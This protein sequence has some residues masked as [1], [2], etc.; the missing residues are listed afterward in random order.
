MKG[1]LRDSKCL[2]R[3]CNARKLT[4]A[5]KHAE[6]LQSLDD[7]I[8]HTGIPVEKVPKG[9]VQKLRGKGDTASFRSKKGVFQIEEQLFDDTAALEEALAHDIPA[10]YGNNDLW[11]SPRLVRGGPFNAGELLEFTVKNGGTFPNAVEAM[12]GQ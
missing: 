5:A 8:A 4:G 9:T 7:L 6:L 10:Y 11:H 2:Q 12:L 3:L 1:N